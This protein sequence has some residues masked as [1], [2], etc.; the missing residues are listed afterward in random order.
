MIGGVR[1]MKRSKKVSAEARKIVVKAAAEMLRARGIEGVS[2]ADVMAAAGMTH[3]GFYKLFEDKEALVEE[4]FDLGLQDSARALRGSA[5]RAPK[6]RALETM[7]D[8]YLS[9]KHRANL[10]RGCAVAAHASEAARQRQGGGFR[11]AFTTGLYRVLESIGEVAS[12]D[13]RP[14]RRPE[15]LALFSCLVGALVL[16][17]GTDDEAL[18]SDLLESAKSRAAALLLGYSQSKGAARKGQRPKKK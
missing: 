3:G 15:A 5:E 11:R 7:V 17:R 18:A 10:A 4:A 13:D 9:P 8:A 2:V 1:E 14:I 6:G 12:Q 16:A